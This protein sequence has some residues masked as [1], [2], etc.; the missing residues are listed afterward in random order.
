[1]PKVEDYITKLFSVIDCGMKFNTMQIWLLTQQKL[2]KPEET[3][4]QI[5][6]TYRKQFTQVRRRTA[7]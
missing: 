5:L 4:S 1:M 3:V 6:R 2:L 7:S